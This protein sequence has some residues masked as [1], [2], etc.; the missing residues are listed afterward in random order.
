MARRELTVARFEEIKRLIAEGRSDREISRALQCR[1]MK[2]AEIRR[3]D[4]RD[5]GLPKL[6]RG[7]LWAEQVDWEDVKRELGFKHPL[8]YLWEEK[9]SS[10]TTY[11]NF[12]KVFYRKYPDLRELLSV[13]RDF[14]PGERSEVDWAGG[15]V[16][17]IDLK[18]G[19]V[20][21][22]VIFV[23]CLGYSQ[24]IF[25]WASENMKSRSFL[26]AHRRMYE[27]F[28]GVPQVT[29]PDCTKTAVSKCHR[30]DPDLNPAYVE[31]ARFY[32]TAIVPA[33][34]RHPK[35]KALV[36]GA[37]RLVMRYLRWLY[38]RHTFTSIA[39]INAAL[40]NVVGRINQKSHTRFRVSRQER[41]ESFE[42][43][44][45]KPLPLVPFESCEWKDAILH[46]DCTVAVESAFYSAPH[47]HRGKTLRVRLSDNLVEIFLEQERLAVHVRDRN[48]CG[49]KVL[50]SEHFPEN[51]K[52]YYEATPQNLLCQA[53]FLSPELY[54]LV[55]ELFQKNALGHIRIVYGFIRMAMKHLNAAKREEGAKQIARAIATMRSY[56][57]FRVAYFQELL[58]HYRK[59]VLKTEDREI[60][61]KPGNPMLRYAEQLSFSITNQGEPNGN[62]PIEKPDAGTKT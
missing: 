54:S 24:L 61:R 58:N 49:R 53:R 37:V 45:L 29:V 23:G 56:N 39:E 4:A 13:S 32:S 57:R 17:W 51:A 10:I 31:L 40:L 47:I 3:G 19:E 48:R 27:F 55:D 2:V 33:R 62:R 15:K 26:E 36:E 30:Y 42:K 9:A 18:T 22:A 20:H 5:P 34:P 52:A 28:G 46:A 8:K 43:T 35:D 1:R 14:A 16:E 7:P 41:F 38:R 12:W 21:E 11:S 6:L 50:N 25:S 60:I 44:A 59:Q